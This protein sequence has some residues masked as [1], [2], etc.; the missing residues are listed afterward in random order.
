MERVITITAVCGHPVPV[1]TLA[2]GSGDHDGEP[3]T[4]YWLGECYMGPTLHEVQHSYLHGNLN[5]D[6]CW[7]AE[8]HDPC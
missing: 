6:P 5:C 2:Y 1:A 3:V 4:G 7:R 8:Q